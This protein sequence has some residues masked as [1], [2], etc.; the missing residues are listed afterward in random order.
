M[1]SKTTLPAPGQTNAPLV[2]LAPMAGITDLPFRRMVAKFGADLVVSEMVASGELVSARGAAR[3]YARLRALA[4]LD[5]ADEQ[6]APALAVQLAGRDPHWMS[7]AARALA[8]EGAQIIDINM[9]CPA[10]KVVGG[11]S[12]AAL[13]RDPDLALT[14]VQAVTDATSLPVTLKTRLGWD[15]AAPETLTFLR[16]AVGAGVQRLAIHGRTRCQFY[17]GHADW[18]AIAPIVQGAGVPV[19]ANGDIVD[20]A[21][22][23]MALGASGA[24]GI[25]VGRGAQGRPW[26]LAQLRAALNGQPVPVAP[27]GAALTDL[28]ATHYDAILSHY[29]RDIGLRTAR[30][31]LGWYVDAAGGARDLRAKLTTATEPAQVL[32]LLP[33]ALVPVLQE[34]AA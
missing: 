28:V 1:T 26:V 21:S 15:T 18:A 4:G 7:E 6:G 20:L 25:M 16:R 33:D 2:A 10:K 32:S 31:H 5:Q 8:D 12:G 29:G 23:R 11:Q 13:L 24:S 3:D 34:H 30:K 22:A 9:G 17:T 27:R 19:L 14:L